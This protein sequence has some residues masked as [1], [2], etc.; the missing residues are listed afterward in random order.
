MRDNSAKKI[1]D[2][3]EIILNRKFEFSL[4]DYDDSDFYVCYENINGFRFP[5][6][7]W[8]TKGIVKNV[9]NTFIAFETFIERNFI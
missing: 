7:E 6:Y 8:C 4:S 1:P 3:Y 5:Y 9:P 2:G